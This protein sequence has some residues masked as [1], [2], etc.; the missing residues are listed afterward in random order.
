MSTNSSAL[1]WVDDIFI[2]KAFYYFFDL[3][4]SGLIVLWIFIFKVYASV[5]SKK[6]HK[7]MSFTKYYAIEVGNI[8]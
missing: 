4:Y 6:V 7:A 8:P 1:T 5:V 2:R 3:G